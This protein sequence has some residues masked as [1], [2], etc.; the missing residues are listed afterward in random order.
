MAE[1]V[2]GNTAFALACYAKLRDQQPDSFFFSPYSISTA[3][4]LT[5]AGARGE[6]AAQMAQTLHF[7]A[8]QTAFH[9]AF[10]E[11]MAR[12]AAIQAAGNVTLQ[13]ANAL[14]V[15]QDHQLR[16]EFLD[17]AA[18]FYHAL[19]LTVNFVGAT[20]EARQR[21]NRWVAEQTAQKIQ[22]LLPPGAINEL[23]RLLLTN[24]MYFK[25][26]WALNFDPAQTQDAA[27]WVTAQQERA[28]PLMHQ[29]ALF[30]YAEDATLQIL[31]MFYQGD[32]VA[33]TIL[34]PKERDGLAALERALTPAQF[35]D[36]LAQAAL[37]E[38]DVFVPKWTLSS[39]FQ[40]AAVLKSLGLTAAF[41]DQADFSGMSADQQLSIADVVH[42]AF[43]EVNEAGT[44]AAAATGVMIGVTSAREPQP[45]PV[46]RADHPFIFLIQD[47]LTGSLLFLGRI[48][49]PAS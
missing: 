7:A 34:L 36:W 48:V 38:V 30:K 31:Q 5:Y 14:W 28:V 10:G 41:S 49:T 29:Q 33:L 44:E 17:T 18:Q 42:K 13:L 24:A 23:T 19:P 32:E 11:L 47:Q 22:N 25:G 45:V 2:N 16:Q 3:L 6:T 35:A 8:D 46:F 9:P 43:V 37:R 1:L 12:L 21:I 39:E 4:A 40:L 26:Q 20:E 27:F 15:Q